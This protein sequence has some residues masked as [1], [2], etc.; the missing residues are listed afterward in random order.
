V[1]K[2]DAIEVSEGE[3]EANAHLI[4]A[5]PDLLEACQEGLAFVAGDDPLDRRAWEQMAATFRAV[6]AKAEATG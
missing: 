5:A 4:K 1:T 6:I 3:T 2:A